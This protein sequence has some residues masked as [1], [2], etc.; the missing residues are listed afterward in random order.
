[1]TNSEYDYC[2]RR[3][4]YAFFSYADP[5]PYNE[6]KAREAW[7]DGFFAAIEEDR[8]NRDRKTIRNEQ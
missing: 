5:C 1:M 3:G 6:H 4:Y 2:F 7:R 8:Q